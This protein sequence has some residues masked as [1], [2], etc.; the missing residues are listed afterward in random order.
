MEGCVPP[1]RS[2]PP[3]T[4]QQ[5]AAAPHAYLRVSRY[6][7]SPPG[8]CQQ[9]ESQALAWVAFCNGFTSIKVYFGPWDAMP[10]QSIYMYRVSW[11]GA[12]VN[13][14]LQRLLLES[15]A[16][17]SVDKGSLPYLVDCTLLS[18]QVL[19]F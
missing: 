14:Q 9:L 3:N 2:S 4:F 6:L 7:T 1:P 10:G 19:S 13:Q 12:I 18:H 16:N 11:T 15:I 8:L 17:G 5:A